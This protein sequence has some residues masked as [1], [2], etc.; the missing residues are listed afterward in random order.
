MAQLVCQGKQNFLTKYPTI[1]LPKWKFEYVYPHSKEGRGQRSGINTIK[2]HTWPSTQYGKM[3]HTRK[4]SWKP[5]VM[6]HNLWHQTISDDILKD[7]C[8]QN[9]NLGKY[10]VRYGVWNLVLWQ[11]VS[12]AVRRDFRQYF[13]QY[14]SPHQMK[15]LNIVISLECCKPHKVTCYPMKCDIM[16]SNYFWQFI[17]GYSVANF[18]CYLIRRHITKSSALEYR[19]YYHKF[20]T[21][22]NEMLYYKSKCIKI[23][24]IL[25]FLMHLQ[26]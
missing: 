25:G 13:W 3:T 15:I 9:F 22:S 16:T 2:Y 14:T 8:I 6:W 24:H 21:L 7:N 18:W 19:I 4:P 11:V 10:I 1:Y 20:L 12:R 23:H 26:M 17:E 5:H